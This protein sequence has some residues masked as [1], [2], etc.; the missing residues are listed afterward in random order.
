MLFP[1]HP[2]K[3]FQYV[4][5]LGSVTHHHLKLQHSATIVFQIK[6]IYENLSCSATFKYT[7]STG[8]LVF[9]RISR[10]SS[11]VQLVLKLSS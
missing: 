10:Q 11:G 1:L 6:L 5:I 7:P 9:V 3:E 4:S 8:M 2:T